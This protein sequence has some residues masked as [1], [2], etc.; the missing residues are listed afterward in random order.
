MGKESFGNVKKSRD[1]RS[2]VH[3]AL[4]SG[5]G[6]SE[7]NQRSFAMPALLNWKLEL[8]PIVPYFH[9]RLGINSQ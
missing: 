5:H 4:V 3:K 2:L 9:F 1:G 7:D 8:M 6:P